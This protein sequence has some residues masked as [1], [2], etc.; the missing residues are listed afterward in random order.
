MR[1]RFFSIM[2][3]R[4]LDGL[5][6]D[7]PR[8]SDLDLVVVHGGFARG[9]T[10]FLDTIAAAKESV[11]NY[12]SPDGRW[13]SLVGSSTGS[14]KIRIDWE[15][16]DEE[17]ARAGSNETLL[18]GESILG[19]AALPPEHPKLLHALLNHPGD[20]E[21]GSVHY[22][23]DTREL[24]GPLSYGA[25]EASNS[26]RLTTRNAKYSELYDML[27]QP[28]YAPARALGAKR[29]AE[30]FPHFEITGLKRTGI[31]FVPALRNRDT[32]VDR[33]YDNLSS[34]EK[35]AFLTALY[36]AKMPIVDSVLMIDAPEL[37]FGDDGAVELVRALLRWTTKTQIIVATASTAV[38]SMPEVAHVVTLP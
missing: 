38:R 11:A 37:G 23:Q 14:A 35:Q 30:L 32:G 28:Q 29:F 2:G 17:R 19:K 24:A 13:D 6:K 26:E 15:P 1:I 7:L 8:T 20:A 16:S 18:S 27:D 22:L 12:G 34:S 36:T 5:Q 21:R 9:K 31:S 4:G 25:R 10:T 3:I 33:I